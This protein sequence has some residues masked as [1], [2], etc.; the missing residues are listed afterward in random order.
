M[1]WL[2]ENS[3]TPPFAKFIEEIN[4]L[5]KIVIFAITSG[6][7]AKAYRAYAARNEQ[8]TSDAVTKPTDSGLKRA[9]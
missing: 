2:A 3:E 8:K 9:I 1:K 7:A 4:M 6:L 5:R